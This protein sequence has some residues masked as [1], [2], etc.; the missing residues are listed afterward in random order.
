AEHPRGA[1]VSTGD[2]GSSGGG[3]VTADPVSTARRV[4]EELLHDVV[5]QRIVREGR[6][7]DGRD[8]ETVRPISGTTAWLPRVHGSSV[9]TR[10]ETQ[11][12]VACT[13]G[14]TS[15]EQEV[16]A[17]RGKHRQRFYLH[18]AFPPYSVGEVRPV[19][20]PG[21]REIGHGNLAQRALAAL[22][23]DAD[24]FP[25]TIR[26]ESEIA[27][28]NGSS[29]MATVCGGCLAMMDAGVPLARPVAGIAMGL[30][31]EGEATAILSDILGDEDH[32]GDMDFKVAGTERG[33]TA[34]QMDNKV[35][36]L[37][38]EVLA[39]ALDQAR[40]GRLHILGE[41]RKILEAPRE[42]VPGHAPRIHL[43]RIRP[44]RIRDLIG[45][46]GQTI[47]ELQ[48]TTDT[49]IDVEQDGRVR[50]FAPAG[51]SL[52]SAVAQVQELT[53]EPTVGAVYRGTVTGVKDFG[54]FVR[55]MGSYEG[56][57]HASELG[58]LR[59]I[60][61]GDMMSVQVKGADEMGRLQLAHVG[62]A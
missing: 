18:Y 6:R 19:R 30:I 13:L 12:L 36:S 43:E 37:P 47:R 32:L 21:R 5:R 59:H 4:L 49:R 60:E 28:S 31:R 56:L 62:D 25:Y 48:A 54:C 8:L 15:D 34:V 27:E 22:L 33:I 3:A 23:P 52:E 58:D 24:A 44:H 51:A 1:E 2:A 26:V 40:R 50:I 9:F 11:A 39:S 55:I 17:M 7:I 42:G 38:R 46:G 57:I 20:G 61:P 10:G 41:M 16:D 29:S 14:T 45:P 53:G 35:G